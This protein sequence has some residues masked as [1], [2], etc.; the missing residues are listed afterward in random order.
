LGAALAYHHA[1]DHGVRV[2]AVPQEDL[3]GGA[4]LG[5]SYEDREVLAAAS[6]YGLLMEETRDG[7]ISEHVASLI[8]DGKVIAWFQGRMEFGP[9]ALGN[10]SILADP[11]RD[12][13]Q[14][15]L[16]M[17]VK[18]RE[19]FRPFAPIV[20]ASEVTKYFDLTIPSPYMLIAMALKPEFREN[21]PS[22]FHNFDLRTKLDVRKSFIPAVTH[23]DFTTR[24]QTVDEHRNPKLYSLLRT[25]HDKTGCPFLINTSFN[26]NDEPIVNSP[27]DAVKCFLSTNIDYLVMHDFIFKKP[28]A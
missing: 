21:L 15:Q 20:L 8:D 1:S 23:V 17:K 28:G 5:P 16:N 18:H 27:E 25:F 11:R 24:L 2:G 6:R 13:M 3:M 22:G 7:S 12:D 26:T 4:L 9:R 19:G 14:R 10:R